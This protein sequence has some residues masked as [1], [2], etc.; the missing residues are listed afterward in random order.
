MSKSDQKLTALEFSHMDAESFA[1]HLDLSEPG[2]HG[3][4]SRSSR[5]SMLSDGQ[6][7]VGPLGK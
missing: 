7:D 4:T 1:R 3:S 2:T 6:A 5:V